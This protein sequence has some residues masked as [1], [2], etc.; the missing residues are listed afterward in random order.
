MS[1][2]VAKVFAVQSVDIN[3]QNWCEIPEKINLHSIIFEGIKRGFVANV[4]LKEDN[5]KHVI[6]VAI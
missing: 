2:D 6:D 1:A 4:A 5:S 3:F